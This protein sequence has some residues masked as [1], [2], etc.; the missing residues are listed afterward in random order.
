MKKLFFFLV[1]LI[2][3]FSA[4]TSVIDSLNTAL[5]SP[6]AAKSVIYDQLS[7]EYLN[8]SP[9]K[10]I[11]YAKLALKYA[12]SY[13]EQVDYTNQIGVAYEYSG[14]YKEALLK[15][16]EALNLAESNSYSKGK[17]VALLN[18]AIAK[19]Q[20]ADYDNA[21]DFALKAIKIFEAKNY[22][23][24]LTS[25]LNNLGNIYLLM[26]DPVQALRF[27]NMVLDNRLK[28]GSESGVAKILHNIALVHIE[29]EEFDEALDFLER[30]LQIMQKINDK[31]GMAY[32]YNNLSSI[33]Y[34]KDD[35]QKTIE[36]NFM[37]L[38][39]FEEIENPEGIAYTCNLLGSTFLS[40]KRYQ[41]AFD[42]FKR[43]MNLAKEIALTEV[44]SENY[45]ELSIYY[46]AIGDYKQAF[47]C[48][49]LHK[50]IY[51]SI[52]SEERS[53]NITKLQT[54]FEIENREEKINRLQ[55]SKTYQKKITTILVLGLIFGSI[56]LAFLYFLYREKLTEIGVRKE[57]EEKL[58]DSEHKFQQ[59]TENISIAVFTFNMEGK[60]TYVNPSTTSITGF[61][62]KELLSM[63][64]FDIVHP[65]HREQV[66]T[67]GFNRIKGEE[68]VQQYDF[69]IITKQGEI[70]W[71]EIFNSRTMID[72]L[73]VVLGTATDITDRKSAD[74]RIRESEGKYKYLVESI[75]EG[76][77]I[78]DEL[79][80]FTF[81]NEAARKIFGYDDQ[82]MDTMNFQ[83]LV[84][85][86]DFN[87]LKI[88]TDN[89]LKGQSSKYEIEIIRKDKEKRLISVTASP[90]F[91]KDDYKGSIGIFVDITE[92]RKAGEKIKSQ[93][94]EKEV[95]LQEIYHRVKN[96]LQIIS[97][98]LKLQASYVDDE[99]TIQLFRNCQHRVKSMSLV[100]EKLY[101]SSDLTNISFKDYTKSLI[102][103]LF[104]S[105]NIN[106]NRISYELDINDVNLDI[107]IAIPCG[108]I[109]NELITN[110]LKY[111]FPDDKQGVIKVSMN[112]IDNGKLNLTVL[113]NGVDLPEDFDMTNLSSFGMRLVDILI[114]QLGA[115]LNI[116]RK[117]GVAFSITFEND[118]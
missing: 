52:Y 9:D 99:Y 7:K 28:F 97:S 34:S 44:I 53:Q 81:Y 58:H 17:G 63:K 82:E 106:T 73:V 3:H 70:R 98:M 86:D 87:R 68:V 37:A 115:E 60:F 89:R 83:K 22:E 76:L 29:L 33:Y 88:E 45:R 118:N 23:E 84:S 111:G 93:L 4:F 19:T 5:N 47:T 51:D 38:N 113:N 112:K 46:A 27:Y 39:L 43:S 42:Q 26:K 12:D 6:N 71:I 75:E 54:K 65:E 16:N 1:L 56:V 102:K 50:T 77:V 85:P 90:L 49:E 92:I 2:I 100:H 32:C 11:E 31:F 35:Y 21:L 36:Y 55:E 62:E 79:E 78:A 25:A 57:A 94:H 108:L 40:M 117:N 72:G 80:N 13:I 74:Q 24:N 104:A 18:I 10:S 15:Y 105:L 95:M 30:S 48:L 96:N 41:Q 116:E 8:I 67:R 103:N 69:K 114:D 109:I 14:K 20:L 107:T 91:D 61:S 110:A 101:K 66:M 64:F 59:L